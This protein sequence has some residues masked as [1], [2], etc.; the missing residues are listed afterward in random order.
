M[1]FLSV[2]LDPF[3]TILSPMRALRWMWKRGMRRG[4]EIRDGEVRSEGFVGRRWGRESMRKLVRGV[5]R[6][7]LS[8]NPISTYTKSRRGREREKKER[9][10]GKLTCVISNSSDSPLILHHHTNHSTSSFPTPSS[11]ILPSRSMIENQ[12][13]TILAN[14]FRS[15][16]R[17]DRINRPELRK[18]DNRRFGR[19]SLSKS[20][21]ERCGASSFAR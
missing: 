2:L 7:H 21:S 6:D 20:P 4:K 18:S 17:S 16:R 14:R 8:S 13:H 12:S 15:Q 10:K 5:L 19:V 11:S 3:P 1:G 9:T